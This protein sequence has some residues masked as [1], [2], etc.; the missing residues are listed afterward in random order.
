MNY[1]QT[2][3]AAIECFKAHLVPFVRSS[4]G[5]GKSAIFA[6]IAKE[7]DLEFIDYRVSG[8]EPTDFTGFPKID[9][10]SGTASYVPFDT[11]PLDTTPLPAGKK[12]WLLFLD[13]LNHGAPAILRA[14]Y[15]LLLNRM[16]GQRHLHKDVILAAAGNLDTDNAHTGKIGTA[17]Q[18]R[19]ISLFLENDPKEWLKWAGGANL[20]YRITSFIGF[21]PDALHSFKPDNVDANFPCQRTWEFVHKLIYKIPTLNAGHIPLISGAI[22]EGMAREFVGYCNVFGQLPTI[23]EIEAN[24][25]SA[26][27]PA[28]PGGKFGVSG[29][30]GSHATVQNINAIVEYASRLDLEFTVITMQDALRRKRE[31]LQTEAMQEWSKNNRKHLV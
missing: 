3:A 9:S 2:K 6:E 25:S 15:K 23:Q 20:D 10:V 24:P 19:V 18:S 7:F 17:L 5:M 22:G 29:L 1:Q 16:V 28:D 31:L 27:L 30:L 4:P 14:S 8:A 21:K 26:K 13:E 12:G 11:F